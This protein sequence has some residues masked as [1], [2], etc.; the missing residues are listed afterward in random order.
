MM[1][2]KIVFVLVFLVS[3]FISA[4]SQILLKKSANRVYENK[5]KE[6]LNPYVIIAYG[7]FFLSTLVTVLAYSKIEMTLGPVLEATGYLHVAILSYI[8]LKEKLTMKK[9]A[10]FGLIILGGIIFSL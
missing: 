6:Y 3:V 4:F 10:G 1:N 5:L 2:N 8:F 7:L 9:L